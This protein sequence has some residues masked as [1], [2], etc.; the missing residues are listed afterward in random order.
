M[1]KI[2]A[3]LDQSRTA[4]AKSRVKFNKTSCT[5]WTIVARMCYIKAIKKSKCKNVCFVCRYKDNRPYPWP[6][7]ESSFILYPESANQTIYTQEARA[8]DAGRYSCRARNDTTT[9]EGNIY[10]EVLGKFK[11]NM[12]LLFLLSFFIISVNCIVMWIEGTVWFLL[13]KFGGLTVF[14]DLR[15]K[16]LHL[17][18]LAYNGKK[19]LMKWKYLFQILIEVKNI[20]WVHLR[21]KI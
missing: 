8:S 20:F 11:L 10:L 18:R 5:S 17:T 21:V 4:A 15:Q 7:G 16:R 14:D 13:S 9:L 12:Y 3:M 1:K 2:I 19:Y 6:G